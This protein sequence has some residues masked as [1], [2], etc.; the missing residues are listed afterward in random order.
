MVSIW[1]RLMI[2]HL[3]NDR[4]EDEMRRTQSKKE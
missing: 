4:I 3:A 1:D 2:V